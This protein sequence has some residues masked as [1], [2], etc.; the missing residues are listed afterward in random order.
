M[1]N[2]YIKVLELGDK[3]VHTIRSYKRSIETLYNHFNITEVSQLDGLS[4]SDYQSFYMAQK[5]S[6]NSL[7]GL[8][9][10]LNAYFVYLTDSGFIKEGNSIFKVRFGKSRFVKFKRPKKQ[11]L[12]SE[13][14][15]ALINAGRNAQEKFMLAMMLKTALRRDEVSSIRMS[16]IKGNQILIQGKG[17]E[18][19]FTF[20]DT[21][22]CAMLESFLDE[23]DT[24][25]EYLFYS[26]RGETGEA[27]RLSPVSV[28]NR[29]KA[30]AEEAGLEDWVTAHRLRGTAITL[31]SINFGLK[32]AQA[33]AG[34]RDSKTTELYITTTDEYVKSM[35]LGK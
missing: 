28:N 14:S 34:H 30:C 4:V 21:E 7:N 8:I 31:A 6:P 33:L 17:G 23:R 24:D 32:G 3:S 12:T 9:R 15:E 27:G 5:L 11:V 22:L 2:Q 20:L 10:N 19:R 26:T 13:Q 35:L 1:L 25:S 18:E 29:V 16:D